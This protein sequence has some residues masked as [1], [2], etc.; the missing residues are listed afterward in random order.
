MTVAAKIGQINFGIFK[1][2]KFKNIPII[3][4]FIIQGYYKK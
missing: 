3:V 1:F 4:Q 2:A